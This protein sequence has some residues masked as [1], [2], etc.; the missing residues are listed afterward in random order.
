M[1]NSPTCSNYTTIY[2]LVGISPYTPKHVH[3]HLRA[4]ISLYP[5]PK[6]ESNDFLLVQISHTSYS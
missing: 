3:A 6:V 5:T 2:P 4:N 1:E